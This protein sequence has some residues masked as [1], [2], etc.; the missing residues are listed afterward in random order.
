LSELGSNV[1]SAEGLDD[2]LLGTKVP[3]GSNVGSVD[4]ALLGSFVGSGVA[5]S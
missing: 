1:G 3:L 5:T 4:G 2:I